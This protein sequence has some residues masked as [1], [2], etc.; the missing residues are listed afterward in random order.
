MSKK[1]L[2][3]RETFDKI[4]DQFS[5]NRRKVISALRAELSSA[6]R[7]NPVNIKKL[8]IQKWKR[9]VGIFKSKKRS[10]GKIPIRHNKTERE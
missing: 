1:L 8:T 7:I 2:R 9:A 4:I 5:K 6:I 3:G 10:P